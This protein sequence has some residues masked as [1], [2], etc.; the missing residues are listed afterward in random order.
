MGAESKAKE[1]GIKFKKIDLSAGKL[2]PFVQVG[3]LCYISGHCSEIEG[4]VGKELD[5]EIGYKAARQAASSLLSTIKAAVGDLDRVRKIINLFG[6]VNVSG[7]FSDTPYV[8]HGATDLF[9]EVFGPEV[10]RHTR[11]AV[12][13]AALPGNKAVEIQMVLEVKE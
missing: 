1:I 7:D 4:K 12:G 13:V 5:K 11:S 10:G 3:N 6:M 9:L 2:A 8:I